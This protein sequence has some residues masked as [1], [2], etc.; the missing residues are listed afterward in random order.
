M[1]KKCY[2]SSISQYLVSQHFDLKEKKA[3]DLYLAI[4]ERGL[5]EDYSHAS[6]LG[7]ELK[8][9]EICL[10]LGKEFYQDEDPFVG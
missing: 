8:K 9:A 3:R 1:M 4:L 7:S 2:L 5:V 10:M 6:Y